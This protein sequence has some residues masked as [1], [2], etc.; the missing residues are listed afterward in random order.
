MSRDSKD[1]TVK[2]G[3]RLWK[4]IYASVF[5]IG[6]ESTMTFMG[7]EFGHPEWIEFPTK[8]NG[9]S[10]NNCRRLWH[11]SSDINLQFNDMLQFS[12]NLNM[13]INDNGSLMFES[14]PEF[15]S[16]NQYTFIVKRG[17]YK[18]EA[19]FDKLVFNVNGRSIID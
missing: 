3:I 5:L 4:M 12:I 1:Q 9:Y 14:Y 8:H 18:I 2:D 7:N 6:G 17:K 16:C 19:D 10:Y 11:L 15:D 13:F